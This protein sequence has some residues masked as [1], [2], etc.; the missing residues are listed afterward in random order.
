MIG[1]DAFAYD[2]LTSVTIPDS[3]TQIDDSAFSGQSRYG[4][5]LTSGNNGAPYIGS[6]DPAEVQRAYDSIW[7]AQLYTADPSNPNNLSDGAES[8]GW[9]DNDNG[10]TNDSLGGHLIN[11]ASLTVNYV[12]AADASLRQPLTLTGQLPDG[13]Q[14]G[15]YYASQ[16]PELPSF[17]DPWSPTPEELAALQ[18]AL[19]AYYRLDDEVTVTPDPAT[20]S[21][22]LG[23]A[24][25]EETIVY[26]AEA[27]PTPSPNPNPNPSQP[28][29]GEG[30]DA[31]G[32]E[33]ELADT[34]TDIVSLLVASLLAIIGGGYG[35][36]RRS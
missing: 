31:P 8:E 16:G 19:A 13:A 6:D 34:G 4:G 33:G 29:P 35:L 20:R 12:N 10:H 26:A 3:V 18:Q 28:A 15:N 25:N 2:R 27:S 23:A 5:D 11:P 21:Y 17:T 9:D 7:Y 32:G 24:V 36:L 30:G 14:L 22:V 1:D